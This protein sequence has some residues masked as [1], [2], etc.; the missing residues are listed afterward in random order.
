MT[1]TKKNALFMVAV[2]A[3]TALGL[4]WYTARGSDAPIVQTT[5]VIRG[6]IIKTVS[7]TGSLEAVNTVNVGTQVSGTV[8]AIHVDYNSVVEKGQ[9]LLEI[10]PDLMQANLKQSEA[11]VLSA[12]ASLA[13]AGA[14]MAEAERNRERTEKLF[15]RGY[16]AETERDEA[17]TAYKTAVARVKSAQA[18]LAKARADL[19]YK[20]INLEYTK[21]FS[22]IDG[23][24][25]DREVDEGQTVNASQSA[26]TL[27]TIA[28]DLSHMQVETDID[29]ADIGLIEKGQKVEFTVDAYPKDL[30]VGS[31]K[32][33]RLA[34]QTTDNVVTYTVIIEVDNSEMSL[35]PGMTANVSVI[36][37]E[38]RDILKVASS[39]L[40]FRPQNAEAQTRGSAIWTYDGE[41]MQPFPVETGIYDG[42]YTEVKG[43]G[44][45]EGMKAVTG[46]VISDSGGGQ[47][48]GL[49]QRR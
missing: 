17:G 46:V 41:T 12:E 9:L 33:V 29:E 6:D 4:W 7:A 39:A 19:E 24:V 22:P 34:P 35:M 27:F 20:R 11:G 31:V 15:A 26:P 16:I 5:P 18:A 38:K 43:S 8:D 28:E 21:I 49:G 45:S 1:R 3:V 37:A 44:V 48:F 32:E 10:D 25:I 13:E 14:D 30:F 23:V 2:V 36:V 40:R 42:M 47:A